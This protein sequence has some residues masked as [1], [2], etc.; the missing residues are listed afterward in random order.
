MPRNTL[1]AGFCCIDYAACFLFET[2][3]V[4]LLV[5][6]LVGFTVAKLAF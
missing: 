2:R 3:P 4:W 1:V 6:L 5:G